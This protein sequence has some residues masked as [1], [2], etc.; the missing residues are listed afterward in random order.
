MSRQAGTLHLRRIHS[1]CPINWTHR[2]LAGLEEEAG[3]GSSWTAT[4]GSAAALW[5]GVPLGRPPARA[6]ME[7]RHRAGPVL[8]TESN[9][10]L[11]RDTVRRP[12]PP[13]VGDSAGAGA[14]ECG[15]AGAVAAADWQQSGQSLCPLR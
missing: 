6:V 9:S 7:M 5:R 1:C 3:G 13:L 4:E 15:A 11:G 10:S 8:V 2:S 12:R 14:G